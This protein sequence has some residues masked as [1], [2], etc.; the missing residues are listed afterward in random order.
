[1]IFQRL[2][3]GFAQKSSMFV[4]V[5]AMALAG[6]DENIAL[7]SAGNDPTDQC[8]SFRQTIVQANRTNVNQQAESAI[9]GAVLGAFVG[10]ALNSD[11]TNADRRRG[12]LLGALGGGLVGFSATYYQQQTEKNADV[13]QLLS[14]VNGDASRER[15][16]VT[17]TGR[18][19]AGLRDCRTSQLAS[20]ER[21]V[22]NGAVTPEQARSQ[23]SVIKSKVIGDNQVIS[24][25][26]NGIGERVDAY[27]DA[28]AAAAQV[29]R[30]A[31][32]ATRPSRATP[33]VTQARASTRNVTAVVQDRASQVSADTTAQERVDNRIEALEILV[34]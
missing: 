28:S 34:G 23:L 25:A 32:A 4:L 22:R 3:S 27:V 11:G 30:A 18:A 5:S 14:S 13:N 29:D 1:M 8:N 6:C 15:Q 20:L 2:K 17:Q 31:I 12:A 9:A 26:F 24:A 21:Q 33:S 19:A 7:T 16:L 10:A